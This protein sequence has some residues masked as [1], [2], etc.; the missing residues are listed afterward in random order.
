MFFVEN[1]D[2]Y[3]RNYDRLA[4]TRFRPTIEVF[5][6]KLID[7]QEMLETPLIVFCSFAI[8]A[9]IWNIAVV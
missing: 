7:T 5:A 8:R 1:S 4:L 2:Q 3:L 6:K 9:K